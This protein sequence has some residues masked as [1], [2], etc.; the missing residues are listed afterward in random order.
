LLRQL[1]TGKLRYVKKRLSPHCRKISVICGLSLLVEAPRLL[2]GEPP[3]A[4]I[5][6]FNSYSKEVES[7]LARQHRSRN[8]F[9]APAASNSESAETRL[10]HGEPI[11]ERVMPSIAANFSVA[12]LHHWRGTAFAPGAKAADFERL[13]RDFN[14]YP[15]HFSPRVLKAKA[16][17]QGDRLQV[18]MRVRQQHVI[19]VVMD[20][21]Y[22]VTFGQLDAQHG[23]STSQ[24][25]RIAEIDSPGTSAERAL[26]ANEEHGFLWR[27]NTYWS[28]EERDGG[29]YL[30]IEAVSLTRSIPRGLGWAI[31]PYV[32]SIPRESLEFTLRSGCNALRKGRQ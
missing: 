17:T 26:N 23:Y 19:T 3:P 27:L 28:Y 9:L 11:I 30:Q 20:T 32:E 8:A 31:R 7:R 10:R 4:A 18:G 2:L 29:L 16:F 21:T 12:L 13:L 1:E 22:D 5:S 14:S 15:Q 25:T 24:S 6:A